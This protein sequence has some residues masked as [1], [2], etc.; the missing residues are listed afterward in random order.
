M[1]YSSGGKQQTT[2]TTYCF[3]RQKINA[4]VYE[5]YGLS[6]EEIR[7]WRDWKKKVSNKDEKNY[8]RV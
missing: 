6:K 3:Y 5:L 7:L 1:N 4:L 8:R 2:K